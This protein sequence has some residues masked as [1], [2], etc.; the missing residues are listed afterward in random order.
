MPHRADTHP[1]L[2]TARD[3]L[4]LELTTVDL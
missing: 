2:G 4:R 1:Q 3:Y